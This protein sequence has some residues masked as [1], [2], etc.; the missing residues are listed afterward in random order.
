MRID[1]PN[2]F[3]DKYTPHG[4]YEK[5]LL[6]HQYGLLEVEQVACVGAVAIR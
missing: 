3:R 5:S 6:H 1:T 2:L 4:A